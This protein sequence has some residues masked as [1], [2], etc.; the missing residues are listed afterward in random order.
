MQQNAREN[1]RTNN[2]ISDL[3]TNRPEPH[4]N[5][6]KLASFGSYAGTSST[7]ETLIITSEIGGEFL[8]GI[9][10]QL[11]KTRSENFHIITTRKPAL[12]NVN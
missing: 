1:K 8:F 2:L 6:G 12:D 10:L 4:L 11:L 7:N 5:C 9:E 3:H